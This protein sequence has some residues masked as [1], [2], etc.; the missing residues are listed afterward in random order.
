MTTHLPQ[1][2]AAADAWLVDLAC[3]TGDAPDEA[4]RHVTECSRCA[5][6][7]R[8]LSG[9]RSAAA[10]LPLLEPSGELDRKLLAAVDEELARVAND[11]PT[12]SDR[13]A[14]VVPLFR[15]KWFAPLSVAAAMAILVGLQLL[16]GPGFARSRGGTE[17]SSAAPSMAAKEIQVEAFEAAP[18]RLAEAVAEVDVDVFAQ[19]RAPSPA[20]APPSTASRKRSVARDAPVQKALPPPPAAAMADTSVPSSPASSDAVAADAAPRANAEVISGAMAGAATPSLRA[21][22]PRAASPRMDART[23]S[24]TAP[25]AFAAVADTADPAPVAAEAVAPSLEADEVVDDVD[26]IAVAPAGDVAGVAEL[27]ARAHGA[28]A[29]GQPHRALS[30]Y[31]EVTSLPRATEL[32]LREAALGEVRILLE[33]K[34]MSQAA[35]RAEAAR[36]RFPS[37]S[38]ALDELLAGQEND[39]SS[40]PRAAPASGP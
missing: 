26:A 32:E 39:V 35:R 7:L 20:E 17:E 11:R 25:R 34:Q 3:D 28:H 33:L 13:A 19:A 6:E 37:L 10:S 4:R 8:A 36:K 27:L 24:A 31:R 30:L 5:D 29:E 40:A 2:C 1:S 16:E 18:K 9:V 15:R 38:P 12:S 22:P 14:T 21:P 23:E